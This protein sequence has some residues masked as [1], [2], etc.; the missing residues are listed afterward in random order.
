MS[1]SQTPAESHTSNTYDFS[2]PPAT[3]SFEPAG[4]DGADLQLSLKP[5]DVASGRY[6]I[7]SLIGHGGMGIVYKVE[8]IFLRKEL[9]MKVL[10]T[11]CVSD[12]TVRRFQTEA[13]AAFGIDHPNLISVHDFGLLDDKVPFLVMDY[14]DGESLSERIATRG[15]LEVNEAVPIF[16]RICFGLGYAHQQGVIHRDI[17][18]SNIML[19]AG[20]DVRDEGSVK[21]V[22]FGIAKFT[23]V[24]KNDIQALTR[25]GEVFGS[26][27]YMSPEQCSGNPVDERSDIYSLGCVFFEALTGTTPFVGANALSTMMLHMGERTPSM[28]EAS[29]GKDFPPLLEQ[30]IVK[31]LA[32][33]A[34]DRYQNMAH[35]AADLAALERNLEDPHLLANTIMVVDESKKTSSE[36]NQLSISKTALYLIMACVVI[37]SSVISSLITLSFENNNHPS[38]K[39]QTSFRKLKV[40]KYLMDFEN[41][42]FTS[43]DLKAE[44]PTM[45]N[46]AI[47]ESI[48]RRRD[49]GVCR[50]KLITI[51]DFAM[52]ALLQAAWIRKI[53]F[54]G[55]YVDNGRL[56]DLARLPNFNHLSI[57]HTNLNDE[58]AA[59]LSKCPHLADLSVSWSSVTAQSVRYFSKMRSLANFEICGIALTSESLRLLAEMKQLERLILR[60]SSGLTDQSFAPMV[61]SNVQ[62]LNV[63]NLPIGDDATIYLSQ[64]RKL[65]SIAIGSTKISARGLER[66]LVNEKL[67][68]IMYVPTAHLSEADVALVAK[69]HPNCRFLKKYQKGDSNN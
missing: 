69:R 64:M 51:N 3:R 49:L 21:I 56:G 31:M 55:S 25:T 67:V 40:D 44:R 19:V 29:M 15:T 54:V 20:M 59:G 60:S 6:R 53:D 47:I 37:L 22:D 65:N 7:Q 39:P 14:I 48:N 52:D 36:P 61:K 42:L 27:L 10:S 9:A 33:S 30:I 34:S 12:I 43:L 1:G 57:S 38:V 17:K 66:L 26:P 50:L 2:V 46:P 62:F 58:G 16:L 18:P 11:R 32:K 8:Q 4:L 45:S 41:R 24:E 68:T 28:K 13:R 35:V 5:G 63:E 23:Q